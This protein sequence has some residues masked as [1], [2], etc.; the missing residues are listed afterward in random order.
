VFSALAYYHD[1]KEE[2]DQAR[3]ENSYEYWLEHHAQP[4]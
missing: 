4:A 3:Y 2:I 1:H